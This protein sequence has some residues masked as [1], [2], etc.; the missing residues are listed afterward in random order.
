M[1]QS[2]VATPEIPFMGQKGETVNS[3]AHG[4]MAVLA[5][6]QRVTS[7]DVL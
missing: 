6:G 2:K 4:P 3:S 1:N 5:V 7:I